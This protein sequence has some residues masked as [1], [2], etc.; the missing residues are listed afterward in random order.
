MEVGINPSVA[1]GTVPST[2]PGHFGRVFLISLHKVG[3]LMCAL[4]IHL[5]AGIADSR[6][7]RRA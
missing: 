7:L 6:L 1:S 2:I 4:E 3:F 5:G